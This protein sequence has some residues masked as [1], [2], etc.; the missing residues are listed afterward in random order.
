MW[1]NKNKILTYRGNFG[2]WKKHLRFLIFKNY[3]KS[4]KIIRPPI[5]RYFKLCLKVLYKNK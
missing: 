3:T 5:A 2:I 4:K 1:K